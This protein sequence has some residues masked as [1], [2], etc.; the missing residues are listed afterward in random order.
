MKVELRQRWNDRKQGERGALRVEVE[1]TIPRRV[2]LSTPWLRE[3]VNPELGVVAEKRYGAQEM[4]EVGLRVLR[5]LE[6]TG[7]RPRKNGWRWCCLPAGD[8]VCYWLDRD[9][10]PFATTEHYPNDMPQ[11]GDFPGLTWLQLPGEIGLWNPPHT[12]LFLAT[13]PEH[14][15]ALQRVQEIL[16]SGFRFDF[17]PFIEA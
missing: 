10:A 9:G 7:A 14:R 13:L 11:E 16:L 5:F 15:E 1:T 6:L 8:H 3:V 17:P 4:M 2:L 12:T